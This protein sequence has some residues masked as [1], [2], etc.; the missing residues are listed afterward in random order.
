MK[1]CDTLINDTIFERNISYLVFPKI[2]YALFIITINMNLVDFFVFLFTFLSDGSKELEL[3][4]EY[5]VKIQGT[6]TYFFF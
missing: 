5:S 4:H 3:Y 2:C 1:F 6:S